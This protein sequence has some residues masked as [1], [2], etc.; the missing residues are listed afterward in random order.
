MPGVVH[1]PAV[2]GKEIRAAEAGQARERRCDGCAPRL[3]PLALCLMKT[4][5]LA[6]EGV[7][8]Y[9]SPSFDPVVPR[10]PGQALGLLRRSAST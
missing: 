2:M 9:H 4:N 1:R 10:V 7:V 3:C 8:A 6:G 5:A